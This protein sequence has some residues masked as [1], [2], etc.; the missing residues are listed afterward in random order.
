M[1]YRL[2]KLLMNVNHV[3]LQ[4]YFQTISDFTGIKQWK[5]YQK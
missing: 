3:G 2:E 4:T 1:F 5:K